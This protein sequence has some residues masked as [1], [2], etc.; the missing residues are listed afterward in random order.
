MAP[1]PS[2]DPRGLHARLLPQVKAWAS[3]VGRRVP[4]LAD[5]V[6]I[7]L[8]A[9]VLDRA[10]ALAMYCMFAAVPSLFVAFSVVGF[11]MGA[12]DEATGLT[13]LDLAMRGATL[14]RLSMWLQ[15]ALPGVTWN[16]GDFATALVEDRTTNGVVGTV[17]AISLALGV[18]A[19]LDAGVRAVFG[20]RR[21]SALRAAGFATM[22]VFVMA[23]AALLL[24]IVAPLTE[25]GMR[26]A[27][28]SMTTLSMGR[29]DGIA[30]LLGASQVLPV[31]G[32]FFLQVRWSVRDVGK[33]RLGVMALGFGALWFLG[34]RLFSIYVRDVIRMDALYGALTGIVALMLWLFYANLAFM[35]AVSLLAAWDDRARRLAGLPEPEDPAPPEQATS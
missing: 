33:G 35:L 10:A 27:A 3:A 7:A 20:R 8:R 5:A 1:H 31:A 15:E 16:P 25:W 19:R 14:Q 26:L 21:R 18:F 23:L 22:I 13:G 17:L 4:V 2:K 32:L 30:L 24:S 6:V 29:V 9:D 28:A 11:V 34:Q 12:V